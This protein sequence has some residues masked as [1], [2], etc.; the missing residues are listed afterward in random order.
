MT[1]TKVVRTDLGGGRW[2][3]DPV[4]LAEEI[5]C[6]IVT[7]RS[8]DVETGL[9]RFGETTHDGLFEPNQELKPG[10]LISEECT[11]REFTVT[12]VQDVSPVYRK[13][14]MFQRLPYP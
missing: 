6:R 13:A 2:S 12:G 14:I 1:I 9:R 8:S 10:Y 7:R 11:G 4:V 3:E 5:C